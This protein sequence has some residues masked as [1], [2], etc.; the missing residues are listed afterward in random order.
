MDL[1]KKA[2]GQTATIAERMT[3]T[4]KMERSLDRGKDPAPSVP[5]EGVECRSGQE[6]D[7]YV[8]AKSVPVV[9]GGKRRRISN[10]EE[11]ERRGDR[12]SGK[13]RRVETGGASSSAA[14]R[15]SKPE[16]M[17]AIRK[18][19]EEKRAR[20]EGRVNRYV[21]PAPEIEKMIGEL[22]ELE[23]KDGFTELYFQLCDTPG[24]YHSWG[25]FKSDRLVRVWL[26]HSDDFL[27][28]HWGK[29]VFEGGFWWHV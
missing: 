29:N 10:E 27:V 20:F 7:K 21:E 6:G 25:R 17:Q 12:E 18:K 15:E 22:K 24:F 5:S 13:S 19:V 26:S 2:T 16:S 11:G 23:C 3:A 9:V 4:A 28:E 1:T 8:G 14:V